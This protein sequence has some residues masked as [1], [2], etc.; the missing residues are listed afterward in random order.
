MNPLHL[1]ADQ[2]SAI[3]DHGRAVFPEECCGFLL[4]RAGE[5]GL[6][7]VRVLQEENEREVGARHNR[8]S[9]S[10][11]AF[12]KADRAA[13]HEGLDIVG[14]YHT[15]PNAPARP[16]QYDLDHAWPVYSY[17]I[18]EVR[19]GEPAE[20]TSWVLHEDRSAFAE[21]AIVIAPTP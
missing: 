14:F 8:F 2:D 3:R 9:I 1:E 7:V 17:I 6:R 15:H 12:M 11:E 18:L 10:P 19:E 20:M 21:Q 5:G 4:G 16:S 13:R